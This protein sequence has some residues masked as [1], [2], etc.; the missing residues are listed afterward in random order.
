[1]SAEGDQ[2]RRLDEPAARAALVAAHARGFRSVAIVLM[3]GWRWTAHEV[4]LAAMA[5]EIGFTQITPSHAVGAVIKMVPRGVTAVADAYLSPPLATYVNAVAAA[6]DTPQ[7]LFM[8]SNGGL[9]AAKHF[10]GRDAILSGP[11]GGIVGMAAAGKAAGHDKLI[12]FDMGGT[13]TDVSH[14]DG[15]FERAEETLIA[16]V[17]VR[18]PMLR[19]DTVAAGGGSVLRVENGR[20]RVG[21]E[22]AGADP[23]PACYRRGGPLTVTD[24]NILLGKLQPALFPALFG[25]DGNQPPDREVVAEKF[26]ALAAKISTT[27][28]AAAEGALSIA[29]ETMASAIKA[30]SIAE[31]HDVGDYT[32]SAFGGAA[33]QHACLVAD[34]LGIR[35]IMAHP[36]A[37]V[38]SAYG[39]GLADVRVLREATLGLALDNAD[40]AA[41]VTAQAAA[42][43]AAA[44]TALAKQKL[45]FDS[46]AI[47]AR[48]RIRYAGS[49]TP[50]DVALDT[51]AA[52]ATAF[53]AE[54]AR[55][56]GFLAQGGDLVVDS[57]A[58]EAIGIAQ[59][60][61]VAAPATT[62]ATAEPKHFP[63]TFGGV[64][65]PT[66][67]FD[68]ATLPPAW[69]MAGPA[70][71]TD[72][73]ATT[74]VEPGWRVT[75]DT[76]GNLILDREGAAPMAARADTA[77][78]PVRLEIFAN[79][80]MAI[81]EQMGVALQ[82]TAWSVNIKERLDFSCALFDAEGHLIANAPHMPVH[83]GSMGDSVRA[84]K[85]AREASARGI[86]PGDAYLL[87]APYNGGTH[88]PDVTVI[89]PVFADDMA[90][91][92]A[93]WVAARG[94]QADIGGTTPGSMPPD[95]RHIDDEGVLLDNV[96]L[97]DEGRLCAAEVLTLL[98]EGRWPARDPERCLGDLQAQLAA[99]ARGADELRRLAA[100]VGADVVA[101]YMGHVQDNAES[102]VRA[103]IRGLDDGSFAYQM[104]NG[105][106]VKVAVRIEREA[107]SAIVDF[108]GSSPQLADNFNAPL[109]VCRAAVLYVFRCLIDSDLPMN[110]G[111]MRPI[112]LNVP[113]HS[114]LR[115]SWPA[116][117]VAGNVETSQVITDALFGA[118]GVMA[119]AQGTMNNFTFGNARHQYY[120][121]I[122]GGSGAGPG[123][124]GT[125]AVQTHMTNSRLTDPEVLE[126]R[127]PVIVERFAVRAGSGGK[128]QW[129]GGDGIVRRI[130]FREAM[131]AGILSN[132]RFIAPFGLAGGGDGACGDTRVERLNGR[133]E[134]LGP[135]AR[136]ELAAGEVI[137]IET[138]GGGGYGPPPGE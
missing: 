95:S 55:R 48:A 62:G 42:L 11:A 29:V 17:R 122:A 133:I 90:E 105:A 96:L 104:D 97:A 53:A 65:T 63:V 119:A 13:S 131:T 70:V 129:P 101:A 50:L 112:S 24:C 33:G 110:D 87:N 115:P 117:V 32:L 67:F 72:A 68:R 8:Q 74:V 6:I 108:T 19:I 54:Q 10:R 113:E 22:S 1:M 126:T 127:F 111:C 44:R 107:G 124:A 3:H 45:A 41:A 14:H 5:R 128:G 80:F 46:I 35:R 82:T 58:I 26:A 138:P 47:E 92:P 125:S 136:A 21:P 77:A 106:T 89:M 30:I 120:E 100:S 43:E 91:T 37:G 134:V 16:G 85:S 23:G 34:A 102:A 118:L 59:R 79:R 78:D 2:L 130:R 12:G 123:F 116:A 132:R 99:C 18:V 81:A 103:A 4:R 75:V 61:D 135:T 64:T 27:P 15:R 39:I 20:L 121:T 71:I 73:S 56:F 57:L 137:V 109:S 7:L 52:M 66:A 28:E 31:G 69:S 36:L 76:L 83:L 49:D 40:T 51:P 94:H 9:V 86:R 38:L 93:W 114:M 84:I 25:P 88:L 60:P 98:R